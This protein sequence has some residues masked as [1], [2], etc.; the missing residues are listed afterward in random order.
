L[1]DAL[2]WIAEGHPLETG[3]SIHD[4]LKA[5][6]ALGDR[7]QNQQTALRRL[8]RRATE[9]SLDTGT[10]IFNPELLTP[11]TR[12]KRVLDLLAQKSPNRTLASLT[13]QAV[14]AAQREDSL[15]MEVFCA[16]AGLTFRDIKERL[17][18]EV[19]NAL[20]GRWQGKSVAAVFRVVDAIV[21]G[22]ASTTIT[23]GAIS[24]KPIELILEKTTGGWTEI[25]RLRCSGVPYEWLLAQRTVGSAW[26]AHRNR[27]SSKLIHVVASALCAEL[28][29]LG[30]AYRCSKLVGG[31]IR[32]S[33]VQRLAGGSAHV[34]IVALNRRSRP[35][36][37][38]A[39]SIARDGG[40]ARKNAGRLQ[41]MARHARLPLALVVAGPG[42]SMRN[43]TGELAAAFGGSIYSDCSIGILAKSIHEGAMRSVAKDT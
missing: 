2:A 36:C 27:T 17:G 12:Y 29:R 38:V 5:V 20:E 43:E 24:L 40:T 14:A 22:I 35:F 31:T 26:G 32:P 25:E 9:S 42:W 10:V 3:V 15:T 41:A 18:D 7:S 4:V 34:S 19:P 1:E 16:I 21:R 8:A 6:V 39:F 23:Q 30:V 11:L 13:A 28:D 33:E 37:G